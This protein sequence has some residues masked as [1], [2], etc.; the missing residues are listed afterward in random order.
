MEQRKL[1]WREGASLIIQI[2]NNVAQGAF[3]VFV[4]EGDAE[5]KARRIRRN[6]YLRKATEH[7]ARTCA[8][9]A[10]AIFTI[11][12]SLACVDAHIT[13][14]I[15]AGD[16]RV[17]LGVYRPLDNGSRAQSVVEDWAQRRELDGKAPLRVSLFDSS[18]CRV[19]KP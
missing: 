10:D 2:R 16:A 1:L 11:G 19:W 17:F 14:S 15:G 18:K 9:P 4:S 8:D 6:R 7:L 13:D 5:S 3:P 12:H